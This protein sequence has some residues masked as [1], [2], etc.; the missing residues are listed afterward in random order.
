V[1]VSALLQTNDLFHLAQ[2]DAGPA[3]PELE[4][5]IGLPNF[6]PCAAP[7]PPPGL[8]RPDPTWPPALP[9]ME[10]KPMPA[11][12][13]ETTTPLPSPPAPAKHQP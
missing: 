13:R 3:L 12:R 8:L 9:L 2:A 1:D 11:A 7:L 6:P 10:G 4:G 5:M